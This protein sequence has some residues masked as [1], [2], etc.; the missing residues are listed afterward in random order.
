MIDASTKRITVDNKV[1]KLSYPQVLLFRKDI[2]RFIQLF[3]VDVLIG[4][5]TNI[6][7]KTRGAV[8]IPHPS[9]R[10]AYF[11]V[12]IWA[13]GVRNQFHGISEVKTALGFHHI[14][15]LTNHIAI[16]AVERKLYFC[17]VVFQFFSAHY[18]SPSTV[19]GFT[20]VT[21]KRE[22]AFATLE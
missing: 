15:K 19:L 8:H 6:A 2:L 22:C 4:N 9:I 5:H 1:Y 14:R 3:D 17:L 20:L 7:H 10:H 18:F 11:V 16:L 13:I 21:S 12:D